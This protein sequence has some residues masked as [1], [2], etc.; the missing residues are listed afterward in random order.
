MAFV[1]KTWE[2]RLSEFPGRRLLTIISKTDTEM[3]VDVA[4]HEGEVSRD[5]KAFN[6]A[7]MD[8][9]EQRIDDGFAEQPEWIY[10]E[11][12]KIIGYKTQQG[13]AGTVYPFRSEPV[14]AISDL[15]WTINLNGKNQVMT[16]DL[17]TIPGYQYLTADDILVIFK[18]VL[19]SFSGQSINFV[20]KTYNA[21]TGILSCI[22]Y[23][24]AHDS[25]YATLKVDIVVI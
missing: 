11:D 25:S 9:L 21:G 17:S 5:G 18:Y 4:R 12:G 3:V 13:G 8:D 20:D 14:V 1:K 7:N 23:G 22:I 2:N 10:D 19:I 15:Q 16:A 24:S 6:Q